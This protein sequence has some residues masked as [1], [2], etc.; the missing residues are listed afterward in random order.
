MVSP[1]GFANRRIVDNVDAVFFE[2]ISGTDG[3]H[4]VVTAVHRPEAL[5]ICA[6]CHLAAA[7]VVLHADGVSSWRSSRRVPR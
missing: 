3:E 1:A 5:W 2:V 7:I 4:Q 6:Q